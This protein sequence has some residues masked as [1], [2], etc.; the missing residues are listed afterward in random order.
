[1]L[2][3][4]YSS[5]TALNL[6]LHQ[7]DLIAHNLAHV[8]VPG[9]K[10]TSQ[11]VMTFADSQ[12]LQDYLQEQQPETLQNNA[13]ATNGVDYSFNVNGAYLAE[14]STDFSQGRIEETG[15]NMNAAIDGEGFFVVEGEAGPLYT[16]NGNFKLNENSELSLPSGQIVEGEGG[17][18]SVENASHVNIG[19]DGTLFSEGEEIGKLRIVKFGDVSQLIPA[20]TT[21][22]AAPPGVDPEAVVEGEVSLQ[23][24]FLESSNTQAVNELIRMITGMRHFEAAQKTL[25]TISETIGQHTN[26]QSA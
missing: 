5:A 15:D 13:A 16:R 11:T 14:Y 20:G 12:A 8:N 26:L 2:N 6:T 19:T 9:F 1:M 24:G 4:L 17:P 7:Q 22:F 21:L 3:G 10:R 18:I 25:T 23:S